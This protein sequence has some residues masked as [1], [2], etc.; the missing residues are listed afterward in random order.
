MID[1]GNR[2]EAAEKRKQRT[3]RWREQED[4]REGNREGVTAFRI[5]QQ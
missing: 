5:T 4:F 1:F 2:C 3:L